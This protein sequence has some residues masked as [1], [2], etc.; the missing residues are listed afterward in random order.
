MDFPDGSESKESTCNA[1]DTGGTGLIPGSGRFPGEG[2]GNPL[3]YSCLGNPR[4][5]EPSRLQSMGSQRVRHNLVMKPP[6]HYYQ[7]NLS[8]I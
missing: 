1:G 8:Q 2:N 5:E 7:S 6:P 4:T 3:Q